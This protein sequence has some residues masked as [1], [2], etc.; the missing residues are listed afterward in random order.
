M[1]DLNSVIVAGTIVREL[2]LDS[3]EECFDFEIVCERTWHENGATHRD[4]THV[5]I[6]VDGKTFDRCCEVPKGDRIRIV[7]RLQQRKDGKLAVAAE[8]VEVQGKGGINVW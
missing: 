6:E 8:Y 2:E 4:V 3:Y 5:T 7:G 1:N